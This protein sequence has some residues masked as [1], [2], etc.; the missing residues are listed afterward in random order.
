MIIIIIYYDIVTPINAKYIFQTAKKAQEPSTVDG[1]MMSH[2]ELKQKEE[3]D[4][5]MAIANAHKKK[6]RD[7][8]SQLSLEYNKIIKA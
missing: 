3:Y 6:M 4:K 8:L 2:E 5:M 7:T 1:E